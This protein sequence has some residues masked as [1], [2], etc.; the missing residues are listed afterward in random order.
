MS[1]TSHNSDNIGSLGYLT[2]SS[3]NR[4]TLIV[5]ISA[6]QVFFPRHN[7]RLYLRLQIKT[8]LCAG[9][10]DFYTELLSLK[11]KNTEQCRIVC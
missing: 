6:R 3:K 11:A 10:T 4:G 5:F 2:F 9:H 7:L 1:K 8:H